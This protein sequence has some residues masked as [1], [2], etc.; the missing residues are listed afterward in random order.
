MAVDFDQDAC[1]NR[2]SEK[3]FGICDDPPS[4][5]AKGRPAYLDFT[6]D[7]RWIAW[8]ENNDRREVTFTAIDHCVTIH[9]ESGEME[10][11][12]DGMLRYDSTMMFVEL[13]DRNSK[14]WLADAMSQI[15]VTIGLYRNEVGIDDQFRCYA[16]VCNKQR[17][18]FKAANTALA[19]QFEEE[20]GFLL[21]VD[22]FI[23]IR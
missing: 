3:I 22:P 1:Q 8:V 7:E 17:P 9:R 15:R 20:T 5:D 13:K 6:D 16:Y 18:R 19:E 23:A 21:V 12:C 11:R 2:T 4:P 14:G 10:S